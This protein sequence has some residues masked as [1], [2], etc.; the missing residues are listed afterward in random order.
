MDDRVDVPACLTHGVGVRDRRGD[1]FF[2][3]VQPMQGGYV[4]EAE[5]S[6]RAGEPRSQNGAEVACGAGDEDP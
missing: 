6:A 1:N 3:R 4:E 2:V 5:R